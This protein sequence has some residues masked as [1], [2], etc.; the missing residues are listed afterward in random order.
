MPLP[1]QTSDWTVLRDGY[2]S[3]SLADLYI[4]G[5][6]HNVDPGT[7]CTAGK[8][9][10][11]HL[12]TRLNLGNVTTYAV[13]GSEIFE[14]A[15]WALAAGGANGCA[16][17]TAGATW[18]TGTR[19]G[20]VII[21]TSGNDIGANAKTNITR[22]ARNVGAAYRAF[23]AAVSASE[24]LEQ[25]AATHGSTWTQNQASV[26]AS[27]GTYSFT[28]TVGAYVEWTANV[29]QNGK[30][31][32]TTFLGASPGAAIEVRVDG[33]LV[34]TITS[35]ELTYTVADSGGSITTPCVGFTLSGLVPGNRTIRFTHAGSGGQFMFADTLLVHG[36]SPVPVFVCQNIKPQAGSTWTSDQILMAEALRPYVETA[37]RAAMADFPNAVWV[38]AMSANTGDIVGSDGVHL[39]DRGMRLHADDLFW[40][41]C[42]YLGSNDPD[43]LYS[44]L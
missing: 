17:G 40:A 27:G 11:N 3:A 13:G 33:V 43:G 31:T 8:E 36:D 44:A 7:A 2:N 39:N 42:K 4:Y 19:K 29:Q 38:P 37:T 24:K 32:Y 34:R 9:W 26:N 5:H 25:T 20:L 6:S 10:F 35:E 1:E 14:S 30:V 21:D 28:G 22:H 41:I 15:I 16:A 23:L 12:A 18:P